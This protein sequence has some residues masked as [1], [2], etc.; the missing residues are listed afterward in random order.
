M[1]TENPLDRFRLDDKV[2]VIT[3]AGA[4]LGTGFARATAGGGGHVRFFRG[5][6]W[7]QPAVARAR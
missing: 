5:F 3:G 6:R 1:T 7:R 4:G 2:V